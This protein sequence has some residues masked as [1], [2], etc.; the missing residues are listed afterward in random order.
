MVDSFKLTEA[1]ALIVIRYSLIYIFGELKQF[2][3]IWDVIIGSKTS[4]HGL[5]IVGDRRA[6]Y[7]YTNRCEY[8]NRS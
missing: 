8:A 1:L 2:T 6:T 5:N 4:H 3:C 7:S